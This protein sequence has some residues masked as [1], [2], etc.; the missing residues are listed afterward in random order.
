MPRT[1]TWVHL[2]DL[3]SNEIRTGLDARRILKSLQADLKKVAAE[4]DLDPELLFFTGDVAF[5]HCGDKKGERLADQFKDAQEFFDGVRTGFRTAIE[6]SNVFIVPGNHDI[7]RCQVTDDQTE[8]LDRQSDPHAIYEK[9]RRNDLQFQRYMARLDE[10][11]AFLREAGYGHLLDD[12]DRLT[13]A[14]IRD[15][16]GTKIGIA[17]LNSAWSCCR[18][19]E[20]AKLWLGGKHQLQKAMSELQEVEFRVCLLHHPVNWFVDAEDPTIWREISRDFSF[21][22]HG[23]EHQGWVNPDADGHTRIAAAA[24]YDRSD[25]ENGYC[26]VRVNF[27]DATA[28]VWLRKYDPNGGCWIPRMI[29]D[30]TT[31]DGIWRIRKVKGILV[32][33]VFGFAATPRPVSSSNSGAFSVPNLNIQTVIDL[34]RE[35]LIERL[36]N[37]ATQ[38]QNAGRFE[39]A[40]SDFEKAVELG[41]KDNYVLVSLGSL[42]TNLGISDKGIDLNRLAADADPDN[43]VPAFNLAVS[44]LQAGQPPEDVLAALDA[45]HKL[46]EKRSTDPVTMAK[47]LIYRGHALRRLEKFADAAAEYREA[48]RLLFEIPRAKMFKGEAQKSL[49]DVLGHLGEKDEARKAYEKAIEEF[50]VPAF[51]KRRV[52]AEEALARLT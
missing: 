34:L 43:F 41:A 48:I 45:A 52:E 14:H 31:S 12:P 9:I 25:K 7:N 19:K 33:E 1:L 20:K 11:K 37:R 2:S 47:L 39:D 36:V 38:L 6:M 30:K 46:S 40:R 26:V 23:H 24:C 15:F 51:E 8:W 50:E 32:P 3:H 18:E 28:E 42:Y 49:G 4:N 35:D 27:D 16:S 44:M 13:Y 5:G 22:L 17:G 21:C 10:Y 29:G